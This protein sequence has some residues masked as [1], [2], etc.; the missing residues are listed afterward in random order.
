VTEDVV[1]G[2]IFDGVDASCIYFPTDVQPLG[3]MSLLVRTRTDDVEALRSAVATAVKEVAPEMPFQVLPMRELVGLA[4]WIFQAFSV[5]ASL[6]GLVGLLFAYSGTH[7]V[8]SFLVAQ[9]TREVGVRMAL[10]ASAWRIVR[11]MLVEMSRT[12][13]LGLAAG[14]A[15]AAVLIRLF[16]GSAAI[17]PDFG[18][19][20]FVLGAVIVV[21]ATAV[22]ALVPLRRAA[23]IDPAQALR[24]Q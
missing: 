16:R 11:G 15:A 12:A 13:G 7:A 22:A 5:A 2:N 18:V 6:L 8:V 19:R 4:A 24:T 17:L 9:R 20:P 1:S 3:E 21:V 14:V 10:G 23:R